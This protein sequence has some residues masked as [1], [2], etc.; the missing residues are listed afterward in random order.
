MRLPLALAAPLLV[1]GMTLPAVSADTVIKE[2]REIMK[3]IGEQTDIGAAMLKGQTAYDPA[4]AAAIFASY[5]A[6]LSNYAALFPPGSNTG[7]TKA[8]AAVWSN[9]AGF[10]AAIAAFD[11]AVAANAA[12]AGTADGFKA[13]FTAVATNCRSCHQDFKSR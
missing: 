9:P 13:S 7:D 4:K 11:K 5:N 12:G 3:R 10:E 6:A 2:R 8:T 1:A